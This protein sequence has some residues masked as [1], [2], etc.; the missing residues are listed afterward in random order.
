MGPGQQSMAL[1]KIVLTKVGLFRKLSDYSVINVS[2]PWRPDISD[3]KLPNTKSKRE[4][5]KKNKEDVTQ[6]SQKGV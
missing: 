4:Q 2:R 6:T 3:E 5:V 1:Y